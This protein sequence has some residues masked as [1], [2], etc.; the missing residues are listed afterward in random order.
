[1]KQKIC[2][3]HI[4]LL[5]TTISFHFLS[6]AQSPLAAYSAAW[7]NAMYKKANTGAKASYL[8]SK[9]KQ[10]IYILNLARMNP[11]LFASTAVKQFPGRIGDD[12]LVNH[13]DY[14]SLLDTLKK[15]KPLPLLYPDSLSWVSARCHAASSGENGY[16]G[17]ERIS[18]KCNAVLHYSGECCHYGYSDPF[19][20]VVSLLVDEDVPSL[21]H[22]KI[23]L[24]KGFSKIGVAL[25]PHKTY[26]MNTVLDLD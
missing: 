26:G 14:K 20:I 17:H 18:D 7:N 2:M 4:A 15:L 5:L 16:V 22:R 23:L 8:S 1:M 9:E 12:N 24:L 25:A 19:N 11:P 3:L 10:I 13:P 6:I 21:G